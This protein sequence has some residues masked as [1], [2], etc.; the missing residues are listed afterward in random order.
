MIDQ[1]NRKVSVVIPCFNDGSYIVNAIRSILNQTYK[2]IEVIIVDDGSNIETKQILDEINIDSVTVI[3]QENSGPSVA[4]NLGISKAIGNYIVTLDADDTFENSFVE[5]A[6][7][8]LDLNQNY[9]MVTCWGT[10]LL[11]GRNTG[12]I[13]PSG[14]DWKEALFG[15]T[16]CAIGN[17]M[18]RKSLWSE[19]GGYD[20]Y[21]RNGYED[22]EFYIA[23]QLKD[24]AT[25]VIKEFLFNYT[26]KSDSRNKIAN[27]NYRLQLR[28][29]VF[30]KYEKL[31]KEN[32][33]V[34]TSHIF[35]EL[36]NSELKIFDLRNS[37]QF[38]LSKKILQGLN[39]I[40]IWK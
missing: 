2:N 19:V 5:K 12:K 3:Y 31:C 13:K 8:V 17:L 37:R 10:I 15:E 38:I 22:W 25:Y 33:E 23:C 40:K 24:G 21:M 28:K 20:E 14:G 6:V 18:F 39:L 26:D 4:R 30:Q 16:T 32:F 1:N 27:R 9:N 29:Y 35:Q 7:N 11:D 36:E 34:F